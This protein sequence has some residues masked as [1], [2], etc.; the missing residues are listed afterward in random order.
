MKNRILYSSLL[1]KVGIVESGIWMARW[2]FLYRTV[3]RYLSNADSI[4]PHCGRADTERLG[5]KYV[6]LQ[7]RRCRDCQLMFRYPKDDVR[8]N[9]EYYQ[10][11]YEEGG[12]TTE[13]P[14]DETLK[15]LLDSAFSETDKDF[16]TKINIIKC[17][18][19]SGEVL[20]YGSSWGYGVWQFEHAGFSAVGFEISDRRASFAREK[21]GIRIISTLADLDALG[22]DSFDVIFSNHCLEHLPTLSCLFTGFSRLLKE[23]GLIMISVPNCNGC[24]NREIFRRKKN[25]A[26]GEKHT[27]ALDSRFFK[28]N[29]PKY[30]FDEIMCLTPPYDQT[31]LL[32]GTDGGSSDCSSG[33]L[34][35]LARKAKT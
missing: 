14:D 27:M 4:C 23:D 26:F 30:G 11:E 22:D 31:D 32:A 18:K 12:I 9:I 25:Y 35:L 5:T 15:Y 10:D 6:I 8:T 13:L 21:L 17:Y 2:Q 28:T 24:G 1:G 33:E 20:D 3:K 7:L 16:L 19:A 29:L 34:M